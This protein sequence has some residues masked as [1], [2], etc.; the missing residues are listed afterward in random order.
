MSGRADERILTW[1]HWLV[2]RSPLG[3]LATGFVLFAL[4]LASYVLVQ[5]AEGSPLLSDD[6]SG[7]QP[8]TWFALVFALIFWVMTS[9]PPYV[10]QANLDDAEA[11]A[12]Y[13]PALTHATIAEMRRGITRAEWRRSVAYW[14][15]GAVFGVAF[16]VIQHDREAA[17]IELSSFTWSSGWFVI[18][19]GVLVGQL[20]RG[21]SYLRREATSITGHLDH[22]LE[23][24][25][26]EANKLAGFGRIALRDTFIWLLAGALMLLLVIGRE[27]D[28]YLLP[29]LIVVVGS[30]IVIFVLALRPVH[31]AIGKK[32]AQ[33]LERVR[34]E[35]AAL[36]E[37]AEP[38]TSAPP[39]RL[40]DLLAYE[41]RI[42]DVSEWPLDVP[43]L[44]RFGLF[45]AIPVGS[46]LGGALVERLVDLTLD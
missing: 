11:L 25:L 6:G 41:K 21:L 33:E 38:G 3:A 42:A 5:W 16:Y 29:F 17:G 13:V 7:L 4:V 35:I 2:D 27:F 36:R 46:W 23:I 8:D 45:L 44:L 26:L 28:A 10:W 39:G 15:A 24:N 12:A 1:E 34:A 31:R 37:R 18:I 43:T 20:V 40:T 19:A 14:L 32:K 30:A 22:G 9:L